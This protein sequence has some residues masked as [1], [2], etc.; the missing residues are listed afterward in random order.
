MT[1]GEMRLKISLGGFTGQVVDVCP[2][3]FHFLASNTE[4]Q[5]V[6][7]GRAGGIRQESCDFVGAF[8]MHA[9]LFTSYLFSMR[10][11]SRSTSP[12]ESR[13]GVS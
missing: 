1:E 10:N 6:Y 4:V 2:S 3:S 5:R 12:I 11:E 9:L 7:G 13:L 8:G